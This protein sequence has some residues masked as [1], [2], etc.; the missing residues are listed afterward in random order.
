MLPRVISRLSTHTTG[1][2]LGFHGCSPLPRSLSVTMIHRVDT[3]SC[4]QSSAY[5][6]RILLAASF[7]RD[8]SMDIA[9]TVTNEK[10]IGV[11]YQ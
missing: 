4:N 5:N 11:V 7:T 10:T 1:A 8:P 6:L 3:T 2:D 9:K